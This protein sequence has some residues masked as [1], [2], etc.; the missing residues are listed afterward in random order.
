M[1]SSKYKIKFDL[2]SDQTYSSISGYLC[3]SNTHIIL[4]IDDKNYIA[5]SAFDED[6]CVSSIAMYIE[7]IMIKGKNPEIT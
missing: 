5:F 7:R 6:E 3:L 1:N 4:K 2:I